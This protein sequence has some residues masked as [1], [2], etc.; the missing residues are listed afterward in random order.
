[1]NN[2]LL[3]TNPNKANVKPNLVKMGHLEFL[4]LDLK[5]NIK[6]SLNGKKYGHK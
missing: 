5:D 3:K 4:L 2:E 1:M 6:I